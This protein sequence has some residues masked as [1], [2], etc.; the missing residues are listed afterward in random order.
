MNIPPSLARYTIPDLPA[1]DDLLPFLRRLDENRWYSNFGELV[2]EFE[3]RFPEAMAV[4]HGEPGKPRRCL[5]LSSG[6]HALVAG[7]KALG[8]EPGKRVLMPAVTFP[9]CP[10]AAL[11]LGA[12]PV[13]TD[14]DPGT[15]T[16]TPEIARAAATATKL[17]AVMP[18]AVYGIPLPADEWD[19]FTRDTGIPVIIDAAAA[20]ESQRYPEH[21]LV[22]HSLHATKP[23]GIGEGGLLVAANGEVIE[24]ARR[25][26]NFGTH[27][28][29]THGPGEN[30][31][32]SEF[33]AAVA[34]AQLQRWPAIKERRRRVYKM[35]AASMGGLKSLAPVHPGF[36]AAVVSVLMFQTLEPC[37]I[38]L[39]ERLQKEDVAVHRTYL[40]P[41]YNHP[42]FSRLTVA[43]CGG[44]SVC[45]A[46]PAIKARFMPN[47]EKLNQTLIGLPFHGFMNEA[48]VQKVLG[49]L[50]AALSDNR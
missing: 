17:H 26:A 15:W 11:R 34:L 41:L 19:A 28:R 21:G 27:G 31:K 14:V 12:E 9:A 16:L 37:A 32:M 1:A 44:Q 50:G 45:S 30:A 4:A 33:H 38:D 42:Y 36:E 46:D 3:K 40:P 29:I 49:A 25:Y 10:H 39:A 2:T 5:T 13:L 35:F 48:D 6:Y 23:F 47:C 24:R 18:V 43:S 20:A 8:V 7:L 22:A